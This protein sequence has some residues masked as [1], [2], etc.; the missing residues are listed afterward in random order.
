MT[1]PARSVVFEAYGV[2]AAAAVDG[3]VPPEAFER[4]LPPLWREGE[5][6]R[7][8]ARFALTPDGEVSVDDR[9]VTPPANG[10][11]LLRLE[12]MVRAHVALNAPDHVFVH[13]GTVVHGGRAIL[14]PGRSHSGKTTLV[15]ALLRA[16]AAYGSDEFAAIDRDGLVHPYPKPLSLREPGEYE[17]TDVTAAEL[18]ADQAREPAPAALIA[19]ATYAAGAR[20]KPAERDAARGAL[21]L[22]ENAVAAKRRPGQVLSAVRHAAAGATVL[23]GL[24]GEADATAQ[25]LLEALT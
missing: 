16:G 9:V 21:A 5:R 20:W 10:R 6:D 8:S 14:L 13:A 1:E 24:R 19:V 7:I 11:G 18:G 17:Q 3:R 22:F 4:V 25:A 2:T 23:E 12:S 15:A